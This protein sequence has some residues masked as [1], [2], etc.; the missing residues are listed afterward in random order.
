MG[1]HTHLQFCVGRAH[2]LTHYAHLYAVL[3]EENPLVCGHVDPER[4]RVPLEEASEC[5]IQTERERGRGGKE[6]GVGGGG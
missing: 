2:H 6:R 3:P 1:R 4:L 5:G